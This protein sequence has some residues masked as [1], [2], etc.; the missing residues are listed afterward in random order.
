MWGCGLSL[1]PIPKTI[2]WSECFQIRLRNFF[3]DWGSWRARHSDVRQVLAKSCQPSIFCSWKKLRPGVAELSRVKRRGWGEPNGKGVS[4]EKS[5]GLRVIDF[6]DL[7]GDLRGV[8]NCSAALW[9]PHLQ[10]LL[11]W[12][13]RAVVRR[14]LG[15][16]SRQ[17][18]I[19]SEPKACSEVN[20]GSWLAIFA[21]TGASNLDQILISLNFQCNIHIPAGGLFHT[22]LHLTSL[23]IRSFQ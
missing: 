16:R 6:Y 15:K 1:P 10:A 23:N 8:H 17:V 19:I 7:Q 22:N 13:D 2:L 21:K 9:T 5:G 18:I 14:A 3:C 11:H 12:T 20:R 4:Q